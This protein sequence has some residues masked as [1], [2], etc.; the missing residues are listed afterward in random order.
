MLRRDH[1]IKTKLKNMCTQI[2]ATLDNIILLRMYCDCKTHVV[3]SRKLVF[4]H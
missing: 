1:G 4:A 3:F 2:L